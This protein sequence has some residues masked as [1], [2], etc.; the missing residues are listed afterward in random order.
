[1]TIAQVRLGKSGLTVS[2]ICLGT[3]NFGGPTPAAEAK[4]IIARAADAG[5]NFIDTANVYTDGDSERIVG[6][7]IKSKRDYWI[8]ATKL[9]Y[10]VGPH[11]NDR[12]SSRRHLVQAVDAS[13]ER[14]KC[15]WI[16]I[17]YLHRDDYETPLEETVMALGDLIRAGKI[18]YFAVSNF[19]SWR[20]AEIV[21][22]CDR[23]GLPR[24][25]ASQPYYNAL[26][27]MPEIE[28]LPA[29]AQFGLGVV[30]YSP[31]ARGVLTAKYQPGKPPPKESR[32]GRQ[33]RRMM[34]TEW[35]PESLKLAEKLKARADQ[36]GLTPAQFAVLWVLNNRLI[37]SVIAGPR[38]MA[39]WE[40]YLGVAGKTFH[41]EDEALVDS[42]VAPGHPSTP[43]YN[44]P[45]Y[46]ITGR[47]LKNVR[48]DA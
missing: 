4:R 44:D 34:Q 24:P 9:G 43:G 31:V 40:D 12:G 28:H 16:D 39:Q 7:A 46:P 35:R 10:Q 8:V 6:Q 18:R 1:M 26:N 15:G 33:D 25:I 29:C 19:R 23:L 32:A 13:L 37:S 22:V 17:Y 42:L 27:R 3:M 20:V 41:P 14:M 21:A 2:E 30:P 38:T 5:I 11:V 47:P 45:V 36:R 48:S